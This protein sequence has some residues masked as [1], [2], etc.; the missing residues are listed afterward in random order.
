MK[1]EF[2]F[3]LG[4]TTLEEEARKG[5]VLGGNEA[6][7]IDDNLEE[8]T[9]FRVLLLGLGA[10]SASSEL[11]CGLTVEKEKIKGVLTTYLVTGVVIVVQFLRMHTIPGT[12]EG[13]VVERAHTA[14]ALY[15]QLH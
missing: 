6:A 13:V 5:G 15:S 9:L 8:G 2:P 1:G 4:S 3:S 14:T 10:S 12:R 11:L 7:V